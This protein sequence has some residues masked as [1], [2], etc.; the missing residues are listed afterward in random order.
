M[1]YIYIYILV[2]VYMKYTVVYAPILS[3]TP[4]SSRPGDTKHT[5]R[6]ALV[7]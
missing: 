1:L 3:L 5:M 6:C 4:V 7:V 2:Y